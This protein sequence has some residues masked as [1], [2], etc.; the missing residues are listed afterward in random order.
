MTRIAFTLPDVGLR[1]VKGMAYVDDD[2]WLVLKLQDGVA[3][4]LDVQKKEV[5]IEPGALED[6]HIRRGLFRDRLVL[7]PRRPA[8]LDAIPGD[9]RASVDL[10]VGRRQR[11]D[12][13][14]L[15]DEI[16]ARA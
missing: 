7:K 8:L 5:R 13:E 3:G 6:A 2:G 4:I 9:H 14:R 12:L 10:R 16:R 11:A 15:L 1:E